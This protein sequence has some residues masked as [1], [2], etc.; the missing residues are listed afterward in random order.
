MDKLAMLGGSRAVPRE[1]R[2]L[3]WPMV[4]EEEEQAVAR[5]LA[6]GKFTSASAGEPEVVGLEREWADFV[7]TEHAI[8]V[9]NGTVA[10]SLALAAAGVQPGDEVIVPALSFIASAMAAVHIGA[11]PVFVDI[12]PVSF[13]ATAEAIEAAVGP[14]TRAIVVVHLHGLPAD[15]DGIAAVAER[16]GLLVIE[17]AAQA[18]GALY[19]DR[20]VGSFGAINS[21]S[22]NVSKNL[23]TCGE[24]GLLNTDDERLHRRAVMLRQ[25]GE[26][27][28]SKGDRSYLSHLMGWNHK[29]NAIQC[30]FTRVQLAR[31]EAAAKAR[32]DNVETLLG[33][34]AELPGLRVP[35]CPP[36]RTHA[37]H[38]LRFRVDSAAFGLPDAQAGALRAVLMR[39]L[40]AE[41]VAA[42]QYQLMPLPMQRV[43]DGP[44]VA[45]QYP[46]SCRVIEDSFTIQKAHLHPDAGPLLAA[47]ADAFAKI[48][49]HRDLLAGYAA[50]A[51]YE[52]P[53]QLAGRLAD[54]EAAELPW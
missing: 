47:Y 40:R 2:V 3:P 25:F 10:L 51:D 39:A 26:T 45:R 31:F 37:W 42:S 23:P 53:W 16:H 52:P 33:R 41:G 27:I 11:V 36:D 4:T 21:F 1:R 54:Q 32:T 50:A 6:S 8:A 38:I 14:R 15:L 5:V 44:A 22:L 24:G 19:R 43:F 9:A 20:M 17:D 30:A 35:T 34:L 49:Q 18:H 12:D 28:A 29:P 7:G 13:N 48:W 46:A